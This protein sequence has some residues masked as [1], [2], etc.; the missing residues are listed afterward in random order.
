MCMLF[1]TWNYRAGALYLAR[2]AAYKLG[3]HPEMAHGCNMYTW[4]QGSS[5]IFMG[6]GHYPCVSE[7]IGSAY[8]FFAI[9][10]L[11]AGAYLVMHQL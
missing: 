11:V 3:L 4:I 6:T 5:A 10:L 7:L 9:I 2:G 8:R 1:S